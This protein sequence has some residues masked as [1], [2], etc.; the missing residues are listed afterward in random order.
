MKRAALMVAIVLI[1]ACSKREE[2]AR[3]IGGAA[4]GKQLVQ[5]YGCTACHSIPGVKGPRGMIGPSLDHMASR[6][7]IANKFQNNVQNMKRWLEN[8]QAMDPNNAMP[9]LG[10]T[11]DD[12]RDIT[13]F[14]Y[15]L[16]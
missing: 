13:A 2:E 9:N 6:T 12:S 7:H 4:R 11:P 3:K 15:T 14:L 5:Q 8:P 10:V 16:E 1:A